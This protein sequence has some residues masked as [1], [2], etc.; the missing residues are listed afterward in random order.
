M[1]PELMTIEESGGAGRDLQRVRE[2]SLQKIIESTALARIER[3]M[4]TITTTPSEALDYRPG[5]RIEFYRNPPKE[6][7]SGW[8][9][10]AEVISNEPEKEDW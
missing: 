3:A 5:E 7:V 4:N 6:D 8:Q 1:L 9:G 2:M 10:P